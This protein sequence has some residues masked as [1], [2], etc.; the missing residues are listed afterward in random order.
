VIFIDTGA[1]YALVDKND[2]NHSRAL[3]IYKKIVGK[4]LLCT[5]IPVMVETWFL[6]NSRLNSFCADEFLRSTSD[7]LF[8]LLPMD[9]NDVN[10]GLKIKEK[11]SDSGFSFVDVIS[12]ALC[13]KHGIRKVFTFDKH[14]NI[15]RPF[16]G[17]FIVL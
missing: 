4:E 14:F 15:Y 10:E 1:F 13:E 9:L 11:Y 7:G 8:E 5:S 12:F 2:A 6:L 16:S 17:P 3:K